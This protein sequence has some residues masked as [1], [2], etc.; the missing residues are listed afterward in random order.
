MKLTPKSLQKAGLL[1][2]LPS[3]SVCSA[4][5]LSSVVSSSRA[6]PWLHRPWTPS[7]SWPVQGYLHQHSALSVLFIGV[8]LAV[9]LGLRRQV[10]RAW[11][12]ENCICVEFNVEGFTSVVPLGRIS[13]YLGL[14]GRRVWGPLSDVSASGLSTTLV[15][16]V[17]INNTKK[18]LGAPLYIV[19]SINSQ[20]ALFGSWK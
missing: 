4:R 7:S 16:I 11:R 2:P 13:W 12:R 1:P 17:L 5:G 14:G 20:K 19:S 15:L 6:G 18:S 10:R 8:L 9:C 3:V